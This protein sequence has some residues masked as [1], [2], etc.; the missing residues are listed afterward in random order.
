M[1]CNSTHRVSNHRT[2]V[3]QVI[4][5]SHYQLSY[6]SL[7]SVAKSR[8]KYEQILTDNKILVSILTHRC[9]CPHDRLKRGGDR[10]G[11]TNIHKRKLSSE[12][13]VKKRYKLGNHLFHTPGPD[14]PDT[15]RP[16]IN[17][18][19]RGMVRASH[20]IRKWRD[21]DLSKVQKWLLFKNCQ[22]GRGEFQRFFQI[23]LVSYQEILEIMTLCH[24]RST[25]LF[26]MVSGFFLWFYGFLN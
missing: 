22:I 25:P 2:I 16:S 23:S 14:T 20:I 19:P 17:N 18:I 15:S 10:G 3:L 8:K 21:G 7:L 5:P 12:P 26:Q 13:H 24:H 11:A 6:R 1:K 9:Q 4:N